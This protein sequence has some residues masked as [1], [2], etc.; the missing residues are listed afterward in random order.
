MKSKKNV[1]KVLG[2]TSAAMAGSVLTGCGAA[3]DSAAPATGT[4]Y[5]HTYTSV[6]EKYC[7]AT[8]S[9]SA[10]KKIAGKTG[11][12]TINSNGTAKIK[13]V[14]YASFLFTETT[15]K[16]TNIVGDKIVIEVDSAFTR[17][18]ASIVVCPFQ[19]QQKKL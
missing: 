6:E 18:C 19:R 13:D 12:I 8:Q 15:G 17:T 9:L 4:V 3:S 5:Q 14:C 16:V 2:L 7:L 10:S 1:V 11:K